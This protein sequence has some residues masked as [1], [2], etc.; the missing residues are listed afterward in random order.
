MKEL[1][2]ASLCALTLSMACRSDQ[3]SSQPASGG[4]DAPLSVK[5]GLLVA[6]GL[7][8][9]NGLVHTNSVEALRCNHRRGFRWFDVD[10]STT[11][12][13]ELVSFHE[14][15]EKTAGLPD[16]VGSLSVADLER[17]V[18]HFIPCRPSRLAASAFSDHAR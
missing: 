8:S 2:L 6:G 12:D 4:T 5:R 10:L 1:V 16:R 7:G 18:C 17:Y 3:R 13:G 11:A 9:I 15:D 14:G